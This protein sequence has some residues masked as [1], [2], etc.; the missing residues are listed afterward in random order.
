MHQRTW[1]WSWVHTSLD[2]PWNSILKRE[3]IEWYGIYCSGCVH[4]HL[5][6]SFKQAGNVQQEANKALAIVTSHKL[7]IARYRT[8]LVSPDCKNLCNRSSKYITK[9]RCSIIN[10]NWVND[11][12][13]QV[14]NSKNSAVFPSEIFQTI[15]LL[16]TCTSFTR[17]RDKPN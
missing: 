4:I 14:H 2:Q 13:P 3:K 1:T 15:Q 17:E 6:E 10:M 5:P 7:I 8:I 11:H 16:R 12:R 9:T